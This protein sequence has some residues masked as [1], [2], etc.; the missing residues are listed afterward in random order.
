VAPVA[1][2]ER[3]LPPAQGSRPPADPGRPRPAVA[4]PVLGMLF[5]LGSEAMFFA[6]L[7][8]AFLVLRAGTEAWPPPGQPRLPVALTGVSTAVLL[9]SGVTM[10]WARRASGD[11]LAGR[12]GMTAALG[13]VFLAVQGSEWVRLV[14]H[15]L[16]LASSLYASTF[17]T[18][19]GCHGVH[20]LG[21][22]AVLVV[23]WRRAVA[24]G[25]AGGDRGGLDAAAIYW[26]FVVGVWPILYALV[27]FA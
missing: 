3:D 13:A 9:A 21:G 6:A 4:S 24:G 26:W 5:F 10:A 23:V 16:T 8:S 18:L 22:L 15:G 20:V 27:Y 14:G 7:I 2:L 17:Y 25:W 1:T 19:I 11:V 12:L